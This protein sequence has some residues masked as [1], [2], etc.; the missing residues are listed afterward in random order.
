MTP[1]W[2]AARPLLERVFEITADGFDNLTPDQSRE[3]ARLCREAADALGV[4]GEQAPAA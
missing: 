2:E 1:W 4:R 3:A